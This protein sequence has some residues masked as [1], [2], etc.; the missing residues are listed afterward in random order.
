[1]YPEHVPFFGDEVFE[2][3]CGEGADKK[4]KMKYDVKE[5]KEMWEKWQELK[6]KLEKEGERIVIRADEVEKVGFVCGHWDVVVKA[7]EM[8]NGLGDE[9][10]IKGVVDEGQKETEDANRKDAG[11]GNPEVKE[12]K[13]SKGKP[14]TKIAERVKKPSKEH[15][16]KGTEGTRSS[17]RAKK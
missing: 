1:V 9:N 4:R 12:I 13:Q 7:A 17:K 2:W 10:G 6:Q 15:T 14:E 5:F 3:L 8:V 16:E 11:E